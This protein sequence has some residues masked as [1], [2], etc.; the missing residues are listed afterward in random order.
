MLGAEGTYLIAL[1]GAGPI[2]LSMLDAALPDEPD[3]PHNGGWFAGSRS[4]L[5]L[6]EG[7][8]EQVDPWLDRV[9][10]S[11]ADAGVR[12]TLG[13]AGGVAPPMWTREAFQRAPTFFALIGFRPGPGAGPYDGWTPD[14][15]ARALAVDLACDWVD[16]AG[17][18]LVV[19][20]DLRAALPADRAT[21]A[22]VMAG[23]VRR[24]GSASATGYLKDEM[25]VRMASF[26]SPAALS[27]M[28][29]TLGEWRPFVDQARDT[30]RTMSLD[31]VTIGMTSSQSW[32]L[33]MQPPA[34]SD[35][36]FNGRAYQYHP[37]RWHEFLLDPSGIQL[38][39][40][41]HLE[42]A[43]DLSAWSTQRVDDGHVLVEARDLGAWYEPIAAG[44]PIPDALLSAARNDFGEMILTPAR[45]QELGLAAKPS[46]RASNAA[47]EG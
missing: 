29:Q 31:E 9:V 43:N 20:A 7:T 44:E 4:Y 24:H 6:A 23:D 26:Q 27:L 36:P 47:P 22:N 8:P 39:T 3:A 40:N 41:Q 14:E 37:E 11:L 42:K 35:S 12:G 18:T 32:G 34:R 13:G 1:R 2:E 46:R 19:H 33:L 21:V 17:A 25:V 5:L 45:A 38:L 10:Q 15:D 16:V 28:H 30:F